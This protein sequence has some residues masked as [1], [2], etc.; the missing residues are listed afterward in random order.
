[1]KKSFLY[2]FA[3][4][5]AFVYLLVSYV[6]FSVG[7]MKPI[8]AI[9]CCG[10]VFVS[11]V[12]CFRQSSFIDDSSL[13]NTEWKKLLV[14]FVIILIWTGVS[15]VGGAAYQTEDH[16]WRNAMYETLVNQ[17]WPVIEA[18]I[19]GVGRRGYSYYMGFWLP[20][21]CVGKVFGLDIGYKFQI[22]W[23]ALGIFLFYLLLCKIL[24]RISIWPLIIFIF[25]SGMD[26]LGYYILG[27]DIGSVSQTMHLEWWASAYQFSSFTTQLFWVFNQAIPAWLAV[28]MILS[29]QDA[30]STVL[31]WSTMVLN[32]TMPFVGMIPII[33]DKLL[34]NLLFTKD[35]I[36][37][38]GKG[39]FTFQNVAG[40]G[41]VGITSFLFLSKGNEMGG[42]HFIELNDGGWL[43]YLVFIML[44]AGFLWIS[45]YWIHKKTILYYLSF[46]WICI[47]PLLDLYGD[48]NFC[49]RASIPALLTLFIYTVQALYIG[50]EEKRW[51]NIIGISVILLI[52]A[53]TPLHEINRS[54]SM[55]AQSYIYKDISVMQK[56]VSFDDIMNNEY[57]TV[58]TEENLFFKYL[59][60]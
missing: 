10:I 14:A 57:E 7:W 21:A 40:G 3:Y 42:I 44:E 8:Y 29:S 60:K 41:I 56:P 51:K 36:R 24:R 5:I 39:V 9:V 25:F 43:L 27:N 47:C 32:C 1:M 31:V 45:L 11:S 54:I 34:K 19:E 52:G 17:K 28:V 2:N 38:W 4:K 35:D 15:G 58:N 49:M 37:E 33:A 13:S 59:C 26:I 18:E 12:K 48:K 46:L 50:I 22:V 23:A 30:K 6:I 55:T 53:V 16:V 20:A